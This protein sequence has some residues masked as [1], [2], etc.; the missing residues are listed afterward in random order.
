MSNVVRFLEA[1]GSSAEMHAANT[2]TLY[3]ALQ[4]FD[5]R[6]EEQW[7][8]LRGS[9]ATLASSLGARVIACSDL[10][11]PQDADYRQQVAKAVVNG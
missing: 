1:M 6:A 4:Q 11:L 7:A 10:S 8:I 5:V 9:S 2:Q 3:T